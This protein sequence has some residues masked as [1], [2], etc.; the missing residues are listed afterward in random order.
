MSRPWTRCISAVPAV[1][2]SALAHADFPAAMKEYSA[3]QYDAARTQFLALAALGDPSSQFNLGAMALQ[4]QGGP[5]DLATAV[6]WFTAALDNG[7]H[8]LTPEKLTDLRAKLTDEQR[9]AAEDIAS[10]YDRLGLQKTVLPIPAAT[11]YCRSI[12]PAHAVETPYVDSNNFYPHSGLYANKNG[13]VIVQ[14]TVGVDGFGRDPQVL[15]AVPDPDFAAAAVEIWMLVHFAPAVRD[16]V[17]IESKVSLKSTFRSTSRSA[18][19]AGVRSTTQGS[20]WDIAE[21]QAVREKAIAG[22]PQAQYHIGLAAT[23]DPSLGINAQWAD[24]LLVSAA[25]GGQPRAQYWAANR[26]MSLGACQPEAKKLPWLK[27]A[28]AGGE[29]AAQLLLAA[30]L[31]KGQ[32]S[33]EQ[34]SQARSLLA[35]AAQSNDFYVE[36]HIVALLASSPIEAIRDRKTAVAVADRLAKDPID[37]DPQ[38]FEAIA[39]AHAANADTWEAVAKQKLA[40]KK[41]NA[42]H[43]NTAL[44][45]ERLASYQRSQPWFGDLFA[46]APAGSG[47]TAASR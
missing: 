6:G 22:D 15:M 5:K 18:N 9:K 37:A 24:R 16:G 19:A 38:K 20:V 4:G 39:A 36:K 27:A 32:P 41:A 45:Q 42:L 11:A 14:L 25:Q 30:D 29:G 28:A 26:F 1:L 12:T 3:G 31:L 2:L 17:P 8:G 35:Q 40:I 47:A 34:L 44:M 46:S 7:Y 21:L 13:F 33:E 43:W 10:Q 23:V